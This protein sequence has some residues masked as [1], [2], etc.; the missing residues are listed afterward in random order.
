MKS[1]F[2]FD[3][4]GT[5]LNSNVE[6]SQRTVKALK[7]LKDKG[8]LIILSSGRMY[9]SMQYIIERF[10][11]FLRNYAV[12]SAY[13]GGYLVDHSGNVVFEKGVEKETACEC[14]EFLQEYRV[15]RHIYIND[16]LISEQDDEEIK[17][18]AKHSFVN[19]TLVD[20]LV[21]VIKNSDHPTLK[22]LAICEPKTLDELKGMALKRFKD[23]F[24][25]MKS[26]D[27][28]LDFIPKGV[29]KGEAL[30]IFS[31]IYNFDLKSCYVFG[32]SENDIDMLEIS[33]N[34]FAMGNA[35]KEVKESARYVL[36]TNDEDGVAYAI[37]KIFVSDFNNVNT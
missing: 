7:K 11:P 10:L 6:I 27:S 34:S 33:N 12:I 26:F 36:P 20:D 37:E 31:K 29:S 16:V 28:Y 32:D 24:N 3:L 2:V 21:K 18:Y 15:H 9:A 30:K 25:I 13:N 1:V 4:D 22:I 23:K 14:I 17:A 35:K 8:H 5:L 19:Y